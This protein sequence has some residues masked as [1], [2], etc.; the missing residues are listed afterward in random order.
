MHSDNRWKP[1]NKTC[2]S[3]WNQKSISKEVWSKSLSNI[4]N[5]IKQ[6]KER[7]VQ[8]C[9]VHEI[10]RV[11][12]ASKN[13]TWSREGLQTKMSWRDNEH[14]GTRGFLSSSLE[15]IS[16]THLRRQ[17]AISGEWT[18][19]KNYC[20]WETEQR[21]WLMTESDIYDP[22]LLQRW[23]LFYMIYDEIWS[24]KWGDHKQCLFHCNI[25]RKIRSLG[26]YRET[27]WLQI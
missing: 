18:C 9:H 4:Q 20:K 14:L 7:R 24:L 15:S 17:K 27:L 12:M 1:R 10:Q 23:S 19:D 5:E 2:V 3:S 25:W 22:A 26:V 13:M 21:A 6:E 11:K 16:W 8:D